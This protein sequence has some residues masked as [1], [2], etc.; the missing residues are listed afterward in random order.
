MI[1]ITKI[2]TFETAHVLYNYDGK[3]KN[4]HGHSY[5]LF[6]TV[7]GTPINDINH[8]KNGMVIDF[9]DIKSIV[10]EEIVDAWDHA[11]LVNA[12]SPHVDLGKD[13]ETKGHKVI[14]CPYQPTCENM[15]LDIAQKIQ[16]RLPETVSL[17][18][19]KL[20]ETENSYGEWFAEDNE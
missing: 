17:A 2:F 15:L 14:F 3:C 16:R 1:R 5:K 9:G 10:K 6:V 12:A 8:C 13:L 4:M 18:Y 19:L 7:K 11:V 20:H